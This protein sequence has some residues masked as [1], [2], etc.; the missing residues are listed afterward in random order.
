MLKKTGEKI[1]ETVIS[2]RKII[3]LSLFM[4]MVIFAAI[5]TKTSKPLQKNEGTKSILKAE[6]EH[7]GLAISQVGEKH[8]YGS[9]EDKN[10]QQSDAVSSIRCQWGNFTITTKEFECICR[11]V[12]CEAGNQDINT[13]IMV[14]LTIFNRL[15]SGLFP[16]TVTEVIYQENQYKVTQWTGFEEYGWTESIEQAVTYALEVNE[17]PADMYYFRTE[18]YHKFGQPYMQSGDLYFSTEGEEK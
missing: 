17:H 18:H 7:K 16:N 13:Q 1:L 6:V 14:A 4:V 12:Y 3:I 9:E 10:R 2:K 15:S 8:T 5:I 11:T